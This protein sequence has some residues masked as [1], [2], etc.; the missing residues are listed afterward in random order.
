MYPAELGEGSEWQEGPDFLKLDEEFWPVEH[1]VLENLELPER[2]KT[3]GF[4]GHIQTADSLA[5]R[6]D[7]LRFS[8]WCSLVNTTARVSKL[9]HRYKKGGL[10]VSELYQAD[11][12]AAERFWIREA[13]K[14]LDI[15]ESKCLRKL[16]PWK[17]EDGI[18]VVGGRIE[19]WREATWNQQFFTVLPA[20]HHISLLIARY[21][22]AV[23]GHLGRDATIT[24]IRAKYWILGV[25][26]LVEKIIDKCT[27]CK[28]KLEKLMQQQMAPL[29]PER[30]LMKPCPGFT[31][32]MVD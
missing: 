19:R 2:K 13:Q 16:H 1:E 9:Y 15:N 20:K 14:Q 29:P 26:P 18:L 3:N 32:I 5:M 28:V 31:Y 8:R 23:G 24:K 22:H 7:L 17:N 6:I 12:D 4:I 11:K 30:L 10:N 21:E 27:L 25:R